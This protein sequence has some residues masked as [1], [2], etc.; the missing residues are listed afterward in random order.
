MSLD[1]TGRQPISNNLTP[2]AQ[3]HQAGAEE[4]SLRL[5]IQFN[6]DKNPLKT[7]TVKLINDQYH[8][9]KT[10]TDFLNM[11]RLALHHVTARLREQYPKGEALLDDTNEGAIQAF[12]K[13][14]GKLVGPLRSLHG[15]VLDLESKYRMR[16][17]QQPPWP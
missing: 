3:V 1:G 11:N 2:A 9:I 14:V 17:L 8:T 12:T 5:E 6:N 15:R 13:E 10:Q 7:C 4:P 16:L